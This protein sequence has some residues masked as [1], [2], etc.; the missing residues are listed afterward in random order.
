MTTPMLKAELRNSED[1]RKASRIR[2][3]GFVPGVIYSSGEET[4]SVKLDGNDLH[5]YLNKFGSTGTVDV[6][7]EGK[8]V[9]VLIKEIQ[10]HATKGNVMH[11]DLQRLSED[12]IVKLRVP[13]TI[14][15]RELVE[16]K[17]AVIRQQ[18]MD[19]ELQC[20]PKYI[21]QVIQVDVSGLKIGDSITVNDLDFA[22]DENYEILTNL[23]EQIASLATTLKV[24]KDT[25]DEDTS[26]A[27]TD[28]VGEA[29]D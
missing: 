7:L 16:T 3:E 29:I 14:L 9:P 4:K 21:P 11:L 15:G 22:K 20:L 27:E 28:S 5:R 23:D 12:T 24:D 6:E 19:I 17:E 2:N 18:L 13:V 10:R 8:A 25:E 26:E 1:I